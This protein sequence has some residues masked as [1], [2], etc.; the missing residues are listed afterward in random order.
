LELIGKCVHQK[1]TIFST[2]SIERMEKLFE[3]K[4]LNVSVRT[5]EDREQVFLCAKDV[6]E[7]LGFKKPRNAV[8]AHVWNE[9]KVILDASRSGT[10][11]QTLFS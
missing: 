10:S 4:K 7:S 6:A 2:K 5:V 8:G 11:N 3:N 9:N 1:K